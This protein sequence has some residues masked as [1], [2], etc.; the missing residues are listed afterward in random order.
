MSSSSSLVYPD[1]YD[2]ALGSPIVNQKPL[3]VRP[4]SSSR[5]VMKTSPIATPVPSLRR[6]PHPILESPPHRQS[7]GSP[8]S[9]RVTRRNDDPDR[10][11]RPR[12]SFFIF[13]CEFTRKHAEDSKG[14]ER[15]PTPEKTLSKRAGAIW[16]HMTDAQKQVYKDLAKQESE[17]HTQRNPGYRYKP[18]RTKPT[19]R[20]SSGSVSRRE[21]VE[22]LV[23][24]RENE[25]A[26]LQD[27]GSDYSPAASPISQHSSSPEP[28]P[29]TPRDAHFP[30]SASQRGLAHRRSMSLPHLHMA[31][32]SEPYPFAHTYFIQPESCASSPGPGPH[33][34]SRRS[35]SAARQRSYSPNVSIPPPNP[36][37]ELQYGELT[38]PFSALAPHSSTMS[39]PELLTLPECMAFQDTASSVRLF[40]I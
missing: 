18:K 17:E 29:E 3:V 25:A 14:S 5:R 28:G 6:S 24:K 9:K 7:S 32:P 15:S 38:V 26:K 8:P 37:F 13:R 10:V 36:A 30:H 31:Y 21:Q 11:R 16:K 39:L 22:S 40:L 12:N 4:S 33:R 2:W 27:S 1:V 19:K 20:R 35:S 23:L 34:T